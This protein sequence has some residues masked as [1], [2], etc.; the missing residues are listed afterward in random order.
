MPMNWVCVTP[1]ANQIAV[2]ED[3]I[4]DKTHNYLR[5]IGFLLSFIKG[6]SR[7]CPLPQTL[8]N[9]ITK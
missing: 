5:F 2:Y 1:T 3:L 4:V 9:L 8:K 6:V 7:N